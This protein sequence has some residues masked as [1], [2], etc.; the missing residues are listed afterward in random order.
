GISTRTWPAVGAAIDPDMVAAMIRPDG[1]WAVPTRAIAVEQTHN[2]AG[3][4]VIPLETL[5]AL[6]RVADDA[7]VALHC[8]GARIWH[9]HVADDVPLPEYGRLFDT[10]SVC[11]SKGL[12]APVGSLV[13]SSTDRIAR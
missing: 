13:V 7:G 8:D 1:Y 2:R 11:L 9:A 10:L 3:G 12:G 6:R 4:A 5:R